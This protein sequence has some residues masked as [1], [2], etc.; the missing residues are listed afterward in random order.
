MDVSKLDSQPL[1]GHKLEWIRDIRC[2]EFRQHCSVVS[3]DLSRCSSIC[4][5]ETTALLA[6]VSHG[7]SSHGLCAIRHDGRLQYTRRCAVAELRSKTAINGEC[8]DPPDQAPG[9]RNKRVVVP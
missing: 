8:G 6:E 7:A 1:H 5:R 3:A 4:I 9:T 2:L